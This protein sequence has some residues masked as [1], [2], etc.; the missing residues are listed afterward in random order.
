MSPSYDFAIGF[1]G[2]KYFFSNPV[3]TVLEY[4]QLGDFSR[5]DVEVPRTSR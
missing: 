4:V 1:A 5:W 3:I 2:S